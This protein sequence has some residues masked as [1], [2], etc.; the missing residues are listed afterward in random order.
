MALNLQIILCSTRPGRV[1][2]TV[3]RWAH[4][5]AVE[6]GKFDVRLVD[7]AEV[8]LP[9]YNEPRHPAFRQYE[10]EHTKRWSESVAAADAF[11]FVLPEYNSGTT[12]AL[13]NALNYVYK[14]WN[15]KPAA[16]VSYGGISGG[17]RAVQFTRQ[18]FNTLKLVP[19]VEGV[20]IPMVAQQLDEEKRFRPTE[21]HQNSARAMLDELLRWAEALKPM[22]GPA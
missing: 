6:H 14:E 21:I 9:I 18:I 3:A 13:V 12:P 15:Y 1:G 8:D 11:V 22:R 5:E 4:G 7:L 19:I 20:I 10:H 16:F 2:G 17:V